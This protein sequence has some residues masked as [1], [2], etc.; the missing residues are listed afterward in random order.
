ML[1]QQI[2]FFYWDTVIQNGKFERNVPSFHSIWSCEVEYFA[3]AF[4]WSF[5]PSWCVQ[6]WLRLRRFE[7]SKSAQWLRSREVCEL[8][9]NPYSLD[10]RWQVVWLDLAHGSTPAEIAQLLCISKDRWM[11]RTTW[12]VKPANQRCGSQSL[13]GEFEQI[14]LLRYILEDPTTYLHFTFSVLRS[15]I[16]LKAMGYSRQVLRLVALAETWLT[17]WI[18]HT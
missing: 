1:L 6:K 9:T 7:L 16:W 5:K 14:L 17:L 13:M 3:T 11:F 10:L 15:T 12:E 18:Y 2:S 4:C 8:M